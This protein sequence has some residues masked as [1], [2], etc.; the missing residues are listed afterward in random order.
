M[1][2]HG[3]HTVTTALAFGFGVLLG[4]QLGSVEIV[5]L[6]VFIALLGFALLAGYGAAALF[7]GEQA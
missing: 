2:S 1:I 3:N 7:R 4:H 5:F 6:A